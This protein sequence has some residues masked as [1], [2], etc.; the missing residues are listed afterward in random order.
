M[1]LPDQTKAIF[2]QEAILQAIIVQVQK[3][4]I[5]IVLLVEAIAEA[6]NQLIVRQVEVVQG[7]QVVLQAGV[8]VLEAQVLEAE[9]LVAH[10]Q[11]LHRVLHQATEDN[12]T[13]FISN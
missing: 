7:T 11:A 6:L 4:E 13:L 9:V 2:S 10:L 8:V 5:A 12:I 3:A 1:E